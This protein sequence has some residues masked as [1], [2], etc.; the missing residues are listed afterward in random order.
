MRAMNKYCHANLLYY[1]D[2][3]HRFASNTART[4]TRDTVLAGVE[5][6]RVADATHC[7]VPS[8]ISILFDTVPVIYRSIALVS[9]LRVDLSRIH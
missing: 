4:H 8:R 5:S 1:M 3:Q 6:S 9:T 2:D 7:D